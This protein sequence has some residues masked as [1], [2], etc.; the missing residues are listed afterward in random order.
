[1]TGGLSIAD[2]ARL[3]VT[4]ANAS[5]TYLIAIDDGGKS[6]ECRRRLEKRQSHRQRQC[7]AGFQPGRGRYGSRER[8]GHIIGERRGRGAALCRYSERVGVWRENRYGRRRTTGWKGFC[9]RTG[10]FRSGGRTRKGCDRLDSGDRLTC[11]VSIHSPA[12][13]ATAPL[14]SLMNRAFERQSARTSAFSAFFQSVILARISLGNVCEL[15]VS[16]F[17]GRM[18]W[19]LG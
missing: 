18:I 4:G 16:V 9:P 12:R 14:Q 1:M 19:P 8:H 13:G 3:T 5:K 17:S 7:P 11:R 2:G 10:C 6:A 15:G